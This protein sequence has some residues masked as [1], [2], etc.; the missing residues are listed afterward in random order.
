MAFTLYSVD[1]WHHVWHFSID[2]TSHSCILGKKSRVLSSLSNNMFWSPTSRLDS[3]V[4][5]GFKLAS[6]LTRVI[7]SRRLFHIFSFDILP[8][9]ILRQGNVSGFHTPETVSSG[10]VRKITC[11]TRIHSFVWLLHPFHAPA[12]IRAFGSIFFHGMHAH[13][14]MSEHALDS[15]VGMS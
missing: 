14:Q 9:M 4:C 11:L 5:T 10:I 15:S 8:S 2:I 7:K 3:I 6:R 1:V 13:R 12:A